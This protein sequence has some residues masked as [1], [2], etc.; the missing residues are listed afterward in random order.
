MVI[1]SILTLVLIA[2][3]SFSAAI[4]DNHEQNEMAAME[5][6]APAQMKELAYME[7][8]WDCDMEW[9]DMENPEKWNKTRG[10]A[11][12]KYTLDGCAIESRFK[13]EMLG[14]PFDGFMM[15]SY[16]RDTNEWQNLWIDS[17]GGKMSFYTGKY[18]EGKMVTSGKE[19]WAGQKLHSRVTIFNQTENKFDWLFEHSFDG[20]KTWQVMGKAVYTKR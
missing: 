12:Y 14:M 20:G 18:Q 3:I 4:G 13:G 2:G 10:S 11:M 7:G 19:V 16:D 17:M 1:R 8:Q 15:I 9:A 6:G 5:M